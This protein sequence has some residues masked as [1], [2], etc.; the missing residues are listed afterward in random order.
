MKKNMRMLARRSSWGVVGLLGG[1]AAVAVGC[2]ATPGDGAASSSDNE[3]L[4]GTG[5][6][7]SNEIIGSIACGGATS[8]AYT[9]TP[10]Y[11][12]YTFAGTKGESVNVVA[13][14]KSGT[15]DLWILR[16]DFSELASGSGTPSANVVA[17]IPKTGTYYIAFKQKANEAKTFSVSVAC[18]GVDAGPPDAGPPD[19]GPPDAGHDS[20]PPD[21]GKPDSG[22]GCSTL[23]ASGQSCVS[24][25]CEYTSCTGIQVPGDYATIAGALAVI[26][27]GGTVCLTTQNYPEN[28]SIGT[29]GPVTIQGVSSGLTSIASITTSAGSQVTLQGV[30]LNSATLGGNANIAASALDYASLGGSS[31]VT[32]SAF[33][34]LAIGSAA[35]VTHTSAYSIEVALASGTSSNVLLDG[36]AVPNGGF[37]SVG[38][39]SGTLGFVMQ[40]SYVTGGFTSSGLSAG[41]I[42]LFNNTIVGSSSTAGTGVYISGSGS[43]SVAYFNNIV[44]TFNLG[45]D[46]EGTLGA[47]TFGNNA[48]YNLTTRYGGSAVV[49]TGYVLTNPNLDSNTPPGLLSGSPLLGAGNASN[50]PSTDFWGNAR[51]KSFVDIGAVSGPVGPALPAPPV[52]Q[53]N[54]YSQ[55]FQNGVTPT[56]QCTAWTTYQS[57]LLAGGYSLVTISGS[58]DTAGVTC[59]GAAANT[60]CQAIHSGATTTTVCNGHTWYTGPC[61][62]GTE[63]TADSAL[64][65]CGSGATYT[66]RP[67]I[68]NDN[69]GGMDGVTCAAASQTLDVIC[70]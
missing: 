37:V 35:A 44:D 50:A 11:L 21:A 36:V 7:T 69:W 23:C 30:S 51:N 5:A 26:P 27:N 29:A 22:S 66:V 38:V 9:G 57:S 52:P 48:L 67:C 28:L 56:T 61:G 13:S 55:A 54:T 31:V 32:D 6:L 3:A 34:T 70:Q 15:A 18:A 41:S 12:A 59:T 45:V 46:L 14:D 10:T 24:G 58:N 68:G 33:D 25:Q 42:G 53:S 20:G 40:N 2:S 60:I 19:S 65:S 64:C 4:A 63:V 43:P 49:G 39:Q 17:T 1:C 16:S 47:V 8:V 62:S